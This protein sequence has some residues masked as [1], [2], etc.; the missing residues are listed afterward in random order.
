MSAQPG[1]RGD[2]TLHLPIAKQLLAALT[3]AGISFVLVL[4][5]AHQ[6]GPANFGEYAALLSTSVV[7]LILIEGGWPARLYRD[8]VAEASAATSQQHKANGLAYLIAVATTLAALGAMLSGAPAAWSASM[9]CMAGVAAMNVVSGSLRAQGRFGTDALWQ[10]GGRILSAVLIALCVIW[11]SQSVAA[12]F[13]AWSAGLLILL[14]TV[15]ARWLSWPRWSGMRL[16]MHGTLA[17]LLVEACMAL[18]LK[19][20]VAVLKRLGAADIELSFYAACSRFNEVALLAW[21]PVGNVLL[22][23]FRLAHTDSSAP[24][25]TSLRWIVLAMGSGSV[26]LLAAWLGGDWAVGLL[27]GQAYAGAG[28]LLPYTASMLPF[29][30]TNMVL[31]MALLAR[32]E[33]RWLAWRLPLAAVLLVLAMGAGWA[34]W[35]ASGAALGVAACHALLALIA[36]R[37]L[38]AA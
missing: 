33:E 13:L 16:A 6:L 31:V 17:F 20:D 19:G 25:N 1:Q 26:A 12:I 18:L 35:G 9:L 29:A 38:S 32:G 7:L 14:V 10:T 21:A 24:H 37:K 28:A 11:V 23:Q 2:A 34:W 8:G 5:L 3:N 22:R 4:F 15:G 27:F 30:L 36:W